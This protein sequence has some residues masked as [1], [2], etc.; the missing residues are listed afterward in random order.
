M[1]LGRIA[2]EK[3][4]SVPVPDPWLTNW[5][6]VNEFGARRYSEAKLNYLSAT[7]LGRAMSL[8]ETLRAIYANSDRQ[9]AEAEL[10]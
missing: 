2:L 7:Q 9:L 3:R 10:R 8:R 4:T 6:R 5:N 1:Y